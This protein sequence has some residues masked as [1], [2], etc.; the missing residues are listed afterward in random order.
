M[1]WLHFILVFA[2]V[3]VWHFAILFYVNQKMLKYFGDS[4]K[5]LKDNIILNL[6]YLLLYAFIPDFSDIGD[7]YVLFGQIQFEYAT[8]FL[9][10]AVGFLAFHVIMLSNQI[11]IIKAEKRKIKQ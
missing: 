8:C 9:F 1:G 11:G 3:P 4:R 7:P 10:L 6:T 2:L 5:I